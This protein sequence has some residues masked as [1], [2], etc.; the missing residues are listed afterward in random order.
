MDELD[1]SDYLDHRSRNEAMSH[2]NSSSFDPR[3]V[4]NDVPIQIESAN[5]LNKTQ[6]DPIL[7]SSFPLAQNINFNS[8]DLQKNM[9]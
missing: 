5:I 6:G 2:K 3:Q 9:R 8:M 7:S 1:F 4:N